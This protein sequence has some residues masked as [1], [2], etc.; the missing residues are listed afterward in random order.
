MLICY[1]LHELLPKFV[2]HFYV[3][4]THESMKD[5]NALYVA[6]EWIMIGLELD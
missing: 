3:A 4:A 5:E 6:M 1:Y 2:A